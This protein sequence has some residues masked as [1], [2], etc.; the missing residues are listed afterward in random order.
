MK[1]LRGSFLLQEAHWIT[2]LHPRQVGVALSICPRVKSSRFF[3]SMHTLHFHCHLASSL[4]CFCSAQQSKHLRSRL[5]HCL[6]HFFC[7]QTNSDRCFSCLHPRHIFEPSSSSL[8]SPRIR[9]RR[10]S[11][12]ALLPLRRNFLESKSRRMYSESRVLTRD[13]ATVVNPKE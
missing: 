10:I 6:V 13:N 7:G 8:R 12:P 9:L 4:C 2:L 1:A 11:T 5:F 3:L